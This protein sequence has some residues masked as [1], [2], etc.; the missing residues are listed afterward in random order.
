MSKV[1]I[2][3]EITTT[4]KSNVDADILATYVLRSVAG[5]TATNGAMVSG[6][7]C[8]LVASE[9]EENVQ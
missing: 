6:Y 1:K 5:T 2:T 9:E 3:L 8:V 7:R 4:E